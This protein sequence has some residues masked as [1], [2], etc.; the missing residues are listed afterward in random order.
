MKAKDKKKVGILGGT[1]NPIHRGHIELGL[2]IQQAFQMEKVLYILSAHP[3]HKTNLKVVSMELRWQMLERALKP[4][5]QLEPCDLEMKRHTK[6]WTIDTIKE[7]KIKYPGTQFFFIS[8]SEG[9]LRIRTWKDYQTL[10]HS[11]PF[12]VVLRDPEHRQA[13]EHLLKEESI[14]PSP[15]VHIFSYESDK[16]SISSTLIREKIKQSQQI[17]GFVEE[18]VK[19]I[20][21]EY[22]LYES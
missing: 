13:V 12:I 10:L 7:L 15:P 17:D 16:L 5:P 9:F 22:K 18:E 14:M 3:P 4:F 19:K 11:L 1:F 20:M 21:E 2:Q 8:G 6:S